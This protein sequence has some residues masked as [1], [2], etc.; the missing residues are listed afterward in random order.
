L[1]NTI[2]AKVPKKGR[3]KWCTVTL[4]ASAVASLGG[5]IRPSRPSLFQA[6]ACESFGKHMHQEVI[7]PT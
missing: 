3:S 1:K 7:N 4:P 6:Q 2:S 5:F